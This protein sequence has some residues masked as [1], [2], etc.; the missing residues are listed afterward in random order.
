MSWDFVFFQIFSRVTGISK[1]KD[2]GIIW[3][4]SECSL[5]CY[6]P[7]K[8]ALN[9]PKKRSESF[10]DSI[11][12]TNILEEHKTDINL[13]PIKLNIPQRQDTLKF[14]KVIFSEEKNYKIK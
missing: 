3:I 5:S 8:S 2:Q 7:W 4:E 13:F 6:Y 9:N 11:L 12:I 14:A 10:Q 1:L